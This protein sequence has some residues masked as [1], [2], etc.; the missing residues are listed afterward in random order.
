MI[1]NLFEQRSVLNLS[2]TTTITNNYT[3]LSTDEIIICNNSSNITISL[4]DI[5]LNSNK[6]IKYIIKRNNRHVTILSNGVQTI[7]GVA[8]Y[9]M[10]YTGD[11]ICLV[12]NGTNNW[13][14]LMKET[15]YEINTPTTISM[16]PTGDDN[17]GDE[18]NDFSSIAGIFNW[19]NNIKITNTVNILVKAGEY[20]ITD[21]TILN[22]PY[23]MLFNISGVVHT[24]VNPI[25]NIAAG[26][27]ANE[28]TI[29]YTNDVDTNNFKTG[30]GL[31]I[32]N[33]FKN[34]NSS[35]E[36]CYKIKSFPTTK[37]VRCECPNREFPAVVFNVADMTSEVY[38]SVFN[39]SGINAIGI[40][41]E[42]G[43]I[44]TVEKLFFYG[45][46]SDY[47]Y[48]VGM[49]T[50][51][52]YKM[53]NIC[54][55]NFQHGCNLEYSSLH[56]IRYNSLCNCTSDGLISDGRIFLT[57]STINHNSYYG[58]KA[59]NTDC[60][61]CN[62]EYGVGLMTSGDVC[63]NPTMYYNYTM[64]DIYPGFEANYTLE[65][66]QLGNNDFMLSMY[67]INQMKNDTMFKYN[68]YTVPFYTKKFDHD[69]T[70]FVRN[71]V[72]VDT[73]M[74]DVIWDRHLLKYIWY[75]NNTAN[76]ATVSFSGVG[77]ISVLANQEAI[78]IVNKLFSTTDK[79]T[80]NITSTN[81][82]GVSMDVVFVNEQILY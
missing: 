1:N 59:T 31:R 80:I 8:Q 82:N 44:N 64:F 25:T 10:K 37:T 29:T 38:Q 34:V 61:I 55:Q 42:N 36:G 9:E 75:K 69:Y 13:I 39:V 7:D 63:V 53:E 14:I 54:L 4:P 6:N 46:L 65:C 24:V 23:G 20:S 81:W 70:N 5:S 62:N 74:T 49:R 78:L 51:Y 28:V 72:S 33:T 68:N 58:V 56:L 66:S 26:P 15:I 2:K 76:T 40:Y 48:A 52:I 12:T 77:D 27:G 11:T 22:H 50:A 60:V 41:L 67:D 71:N 3:A 19:L 79:T 30:Y 47:S 35:A 32:K 45:D 16:S 18:N 21:R 73:T 57:D 17:L 43:N